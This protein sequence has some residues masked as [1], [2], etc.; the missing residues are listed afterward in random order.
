VARIPDKKE[1]ARRFAELS[2]QDR[3]TIARA[4]NRGR[5]VE[6][7]AHAVFA[8]GVARRQQRFWKYA[9][10]LGPV[11]G[12]AQIPFVELEA[13]LFNLVIGTLVLGAMSAYWLWRARQAEAANLPLVTGGRSSSG[14]RSG[15]HGSGGGDGSS[16]RKAPKGHLPSKEEIRAVDADGEVEGDPGPPSTP[17]GTKPRPPAP[18]RKKRR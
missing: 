2:L 1:H 9:W 11:I 7:R 16:K 3:R 10:L 13:A 5:A 12:V 15:G 4:V 17:D 6:K 18:R 14:S 8:V